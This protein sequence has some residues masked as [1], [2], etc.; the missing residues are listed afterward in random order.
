M[1]QEKKEMLLFFKDVFIFYFM[2][3]CV[4][5]ACIYMYHVPG[6][7][8]KCRRGHQIPW[9]WSYRELGDTQWVLGAESRSS[10]RAAG[11]LNH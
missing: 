9:K 11:V 5:S 6:D 4:L 7:V 2:C 10:S 8:R 1:V 3:M